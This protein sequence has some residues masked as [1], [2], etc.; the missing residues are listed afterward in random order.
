MPLTDTA[1]RTRKP[2]LKPIKMTDGGGLYLLLNS[3][4]SRWW[5]L[6]YRFGGRRKTLSMGTY[7]DTGLADA[8]AKR[9]AARRLLSPDEGVLKKW[10][11]HARRHDYGQASLG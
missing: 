10:G 4:G 5:R 2:S 6:D 3:N 11:Y 9:D 8:R 1:L 7:P